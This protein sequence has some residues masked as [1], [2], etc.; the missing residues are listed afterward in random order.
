ML[1]DAFQFFYV[2]AYTNAGNYLMAVIV[3][4][5]YDKI[6]HPTFVKWLKYPMLFIFY[7]IV[8][9]GFVPFFASYVFYNYTIDVNVWWTGIAVT[10]EKHYWAGLAG[11]VFFVAVIWI[12]GPAGKVIT[13]GTCWRI[14]FVAILGLSYE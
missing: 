7:F 3:G 8:P 6:K 9:L 12:V 14:G 11:A 2:P 13:I 10:I 1:Q 4:L 5:H